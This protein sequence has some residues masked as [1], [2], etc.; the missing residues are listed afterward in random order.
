MSQENN[1][2]SCAIRCCIM[3]LLVGIIFAAVFYV[4][5]DYTFT[6]A[7]F[8]GIV[9]AAVIA[10]IMG[11]LTCG[12]SSA[13][14]LDMT[15]GGASVGS[16]T[17]KS[18]PAAAPSASAQ[19]TSTTANAEA[20]TTPTKAFEMQ[21][22][23]PLAGQEELSGR[24]GDWKYEAETADAK[25]AAAEKAP[26]AKPAPKPKAAKAESASAGDKGKPETLTGPRAGQTADD[27]KLISGV[28]PKLQ[29][30][31]NE[32][33][34]YHFDQ[35]AKWGEAEI[36]WVDSRLRFKG[37]IERDDWMS[38]AKILAE[39]GETEFSARKSK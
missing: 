14:A 35:V 2:I 11:F 23:Q 29:E 6:Q 17:A 10:V 36:A 18:A 21:P 38:Q 7:T 25:P 28:G 4:V 9:I 34:F 24:K 5:A 12:K 26:A 32:L 33:G 30:T 8:A 15:S 13:E 22:S 3:G 31:L 37:R 16:G 1:S 20:D 39:G 19:T 27:L